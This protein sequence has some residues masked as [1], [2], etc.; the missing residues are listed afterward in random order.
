MLNF[1]IDMLNNFL[2]IV[3]VFVRGIDM[4][5]VKVKNT[6]GK[7]FDLLNSTRYAADL[8]RAL[9]KKNGSKIFTIVED[10]IVEYMK[11]KAPDVLKLVK[12]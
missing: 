5:T 10:A 6:K 1:F 3:M 7:A 12:H 4:K 11:E 8:V 2:E 9:N